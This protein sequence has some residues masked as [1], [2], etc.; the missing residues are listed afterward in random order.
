MMRLVDMSLRVKVGLVPAIL[1]AVLLIVSGYAITVMRSNE[2]AIVILKETVIQ[3]VA[4]VSDFRAETESLTSKLFRLTSIAANVS[5]V[6]LI[7]KAVRQTNE[8]M[9]RV[10]RQFDDLKPLLITLIGDSAE[11]K[12]VDT[13]L[14]AYLKDTHAVVEMADSDAATA[15]SFMADTEASIAKFQTSLAYVV[16]AVE[17]KRDRVLQNLTEDMDN[18]RSLFTFAAALAVLLGM[19]LALWIGGRIVRP[20]YDLQRTISM[21]RNTGDLSLRATVAGRDEVGQTSEAFN[22]LLAELNALVTAIGSVMA[23]AADNDLSARVGV[24]AHG[25]IGRLKDDINAS[26]EILSK[27]LSDTMTNI[28]HVATATSQVGMAIGQISDGA[29]N[30]ADA[31]QR[32]ASGVGQTAQA[33]EQVSGDARISSRN[34]AEASEQVNAGRQHMIDMVGSVNA[35]AEN[36]RAI[37]KITNVIGRIATQTNMLSLNAA[38]EAARAGEA[39]KG[40]AVVA[41]EVGKLADHSGRSADE[42]S[43]LIQKASTD[44]HDGVGRAQAMGVSIDHI[45]SVVAEFER[46]ANGISVAMEQ[47]TASVGEIRSSIE[48]LLRIGGANA[49]AAE[50]V[51]ATMMELLR[52][53]E[54]TRTEIQRFK[55]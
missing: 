22:G 37:A 21:V 11:I 44:A 1:I 20:L 4:R 5:D 35:I 31:V 19:A 16:Q 24:G 55:F 38:I 6:V 12:A 51:T 28:H 18:V 43:A 7:E 30:Q 10:Q 3:S 50:E 32:I 34:A 52:L 23:R 15:L 40:F 53:A 33:M 46:L 25:D 27:T 42:I 2:A 29:R 8:Q 54:R 13:D 14:A 48:E 39:G 36:S 47:Q 26:M 45:C 17:A 9:A 49:V 41:E